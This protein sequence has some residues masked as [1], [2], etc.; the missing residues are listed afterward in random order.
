MWKWADMLDLCY[1]CLIELDMGNRE[2]SD[3]FD[4]GV[5]YLKKLDPHPVGLDLLDALVKERRH[6]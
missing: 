1:T 6:V 4:R 3:V 2:M 5:E